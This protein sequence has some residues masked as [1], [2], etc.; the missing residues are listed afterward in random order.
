MERFDY[1]ECTVDY[2]IANHEQYLYGRIITV[3]AI[4]PTASRCE[5]CYK[6]VK[7]A[8]D[9]KQS[10]ACEDCKHTITNPLPMWT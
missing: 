2:A 8:P 10:P 6:P 4:E 5:F 1:S 9:P 7:P 3:T